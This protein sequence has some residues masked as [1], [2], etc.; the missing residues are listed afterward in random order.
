MYSDQLVVLSSFNLLHKRRRTRRQTK[1]NT[2]TPEVLLQASPPSPVLELQPFRDFY[3][4]GTS[5][6]MPSP[7]PS[8]IYLWGLLL[9]PPNRSSKPI[10][11]CHL[12]PPPTGQKWTLGLDAD[13]S[14]YHKVFSSE[15]L[16]YRIP[17]LLIQKALLSD[18]L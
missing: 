6:D 18:R 12:P 8:L 4:E 5:R 1:Q 16:L 10:I 11:S 17:S 14:P 13:P 2:T 3:S 7:A 15:H 9:C